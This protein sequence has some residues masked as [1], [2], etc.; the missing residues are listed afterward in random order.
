MLSVIRLMAS[1]A[2]FVLTAPVPA[3]VREGRR[4]PP[5][6]EWDLPIA[7]GV[8]RCSGSAQFAYIHANTGRGWNNE[9]LDLV[10]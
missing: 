7:S 9:L 10:R 8:S 2:F 3:S 1:A 4:A 5:L 6:S